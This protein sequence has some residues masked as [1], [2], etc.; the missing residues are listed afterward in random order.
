MTMSEQILAKLTTRNIIAVTF[1]MGYF[2]FLF[3]ITGAM[4]GFTLLAEERVE[5]FDLEESPVLTMLLGILSAA[6]ILITQFYFR[7]NTPQ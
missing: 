2:T 3:F 5:P 6:L 4:N 1:V 7:R